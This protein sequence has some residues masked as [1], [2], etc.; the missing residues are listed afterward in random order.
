MRRGFL[1]SKRATT[2]IGETGQGRTEPR[3]ENPACYPIVGSERGRSDRVYEIYI[4]RM[5]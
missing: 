2:Q 1:R 3:I 5:G 4:G